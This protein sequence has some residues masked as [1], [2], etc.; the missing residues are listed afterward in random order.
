[1]ARTR[2]TEAS[3]EAAASEAAE[4]AAHAEAAAREANA[5][6]AAA[7]AAAATAAE[8]KK[9]QKLAKTGSPVAPKAKATAA[10]AG[11]KKKESPA[12][13]AAPRPKK[14]AKGAPPASPASSTPTTPSPAAAAAAP[15]AA[16]KP[17]PAAVA[18]AT[19]K[20]PAMAKAGKDVA[21]PKAALA[22]PAAAAAATAAAAAPAAAA[23]AHSPPA[24]KSQLAQF[25]AKDAGTASSK[26]GSSAS[27][28]AASPGSKA[29]SSLA[30]SSATSSAKS[31]QSENLVKRFK[32]AAELH[33]I[34]WDDMLLS[35]G[36][37][38]EK[39]DEEKDREPA[40]RDVQQ[41]RESAADNDEGGEEETAVEDHEVEFGDGGGEEDDAEDHDGAGEKAAEKTGKAD[42]AA[43][44]KIHT[45][46]LKDGE[47]VQVR[48]PT[49]TA[50]KKICFAVSTAKKIGGKVLGQMDATAAGKTGLAN[51]NS[52]R[53]EWMEFCRECENIQNC[54]GSLEA[55]YKTEK[56]SLFCTWLSND[57]NLEACAL[58]FERSSGSRTSKWENFVPVTQADLEKRYAHRPDKKKVVKEAMEQ[59]KEAG[60]YE[61]DPL[62]KDGKE[63]IY[64]MHKKQWTRED[65]SEEKMSLQGKQQC[66][67][68]L[69]DSLTGEG[70]ML[71]AGAGPTVL[72]KDMGG[73]LGSGN[74]FGQRERERSGEGERERERKEHGS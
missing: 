34:H 65:F 44:G 68:K 37:Q 23:A 28:R 59:M 35:M 10:A 45:L 16:Q 51:S 13:E 7:P 33:G 63:F 22:A 40:A 61:V 46:T 71:Q 55:A 17:P 38:Q 67:R 4:A 43:G 50:G 24:K 5:E 20:K 30:A 2:A 41:D 12:A 49:E 57:K 29:A 48:V 73:S 36:L 19:S 64:Y 60:N 47:S 26:A 69:L 53:K 25:V 31:G 52:H 27:S 70:G 74:A 15:K 14:K 11:N 9:K 18:A 58:A 72:S 66:D 6:A 54:P 62:V 39:P 42:D 32:Q 3:S 21:K 8:A 56:K 1:M